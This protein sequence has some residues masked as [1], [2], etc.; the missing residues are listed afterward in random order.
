MIVSIKRFT[1]AGHKVRGLIP[2]N[3]DEL[4]VSPW[5]AFGG[6]PFNDKHTSSTYCTYSVIEHHGS[7]HGGHYRMYARHHDNSWVEYDDSSV[8][9]VPPERVVTPDSYIALLMPRESMKSMNAHMDRA[10]EGI[11]RH[12]AETSS[13]AAEA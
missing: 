10:I 9:T 13:A 1:N 3:L 4:D 2:W 7:T 8:T 6:D 12:V 11:R 5:L